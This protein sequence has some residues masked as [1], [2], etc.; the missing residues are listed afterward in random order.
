MESDCDTWSQ[1]RALLQSE[2]KH[3]DHYVY[4][5]FIEQHSVLAK[6]NP[7]SVNT[8]RI[9]TFLEPNLEVKIWAM[10]LRVGCGP[11]VD[12]VS[13][14]GFAFNLDTKG[15]TSKPCFT[16][17]PYI[18]IPDIHPL[19]QETMLGIQLPHFE[20]MKDLARKSALLVPE[21]RSVGWD[22]A[23]KPDGP[24]LIEGNDRGDHMFIQLVLQRG[25]K[26]LLT[27]HCDFKVY[28]P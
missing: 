23:I 16:K 4:E 14:G 28:V 22:I 2:F 19:T 20:A 24:C 18:Q 11:G 7:G 6:L 15:Y 21:L 10:F 25:C 3:P 9:Y 27:S 12:T 5:E 26:D 1:L 8:V 13:Q 17:N